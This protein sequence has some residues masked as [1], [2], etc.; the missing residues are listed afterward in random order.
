MRARM[1]GSRG[2][3]CRSWRAVLHARAGGDGPLLFALALG[4]AI[5]GCYHEPP[6][7]DGGPPPPADAPVGCPDGGIDAH[8][9]DGEPPVVLSATPEPGSTG[10]AASVTVAVTFS[11]AMDPASVDEESFRLV[12]D[13]HGRAVAGT[14]TVE[15]AVLRFEPAVELDLSAFYE[16]VIG[17][18]VTDL[19]GTPLAE[20]WRGEFTVRAGVL[21]TAVSLTAGALAPRAMSMG[22]RGEAF[23]LWW[24]GGTIY[25]RHY[26]APSSWQQGMG[27]VSHTGVPD[28][29]AVAAGLDDAAL[30]AWQIGTIRR[31][32]WYA[33]DAAWVD[34]VIPGGGSPAQVGI[35]AR[36]FGLAAWL[37]DQ[38]THI[39]VSASRFGG[40][41]WSNPVRLDELIADASSL[42]LAVADAGN[43]LALWAQNGQIWTAE[44]RD[45]AWAAASAIEPPSGLAREPRLVMDGDGRGMAFWLQQDGAQYRMRWSS[46]DPQSGW[47]EPAFADGGPAVDPDLGAWRG[48]F[49]FN[50]HGDAV[51]LW[52]A[53]MSCGIEEPCNVLLSGLFTL[54]QGW[55]DIRVVSQGYTQFGFIEYVVAM[56]RH[57]H[58][59]AAWTVNAGSTAL[60]LWLRRHVPDQ[61]W[62]PAVSLACADRRGFSELDLRV[63][64]Q[65]RMLMSWREDTDAQGYALC[66]LVLD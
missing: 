54:Q 9:P 16:V 65:G 23:A 51:V 66:A 41:Q 20:E 44:F 13:R 12:D 53:R 36:G 60:E 43:G 14:A 28:S 37:E 19:S 32:A 1:E 21:G 48:P 63:S 56:D 2:S 8:A 15:G 34:A 47:S 25:S 11:E 57:G 61:S 3:H 42:H 58:A 52:R 6:G 46:Y 4:A 27:V 49:A 50:S 38:G 17:T 31:S 64:A 29:I 18:A 59:L 22:G 40:A 30:A 26:Q 24:D 62:E 10:V 55:H 39:G 33:N 7:Q 45:G 35:D 5:S